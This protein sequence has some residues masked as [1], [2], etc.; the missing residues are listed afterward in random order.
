MHPDSRA[1]LDM[2]ATGRIVADAGILVGAT[3]QASA[4]AS[5]QVAAA[6]GEAR[7]IGHDRLAGLGTTVLGEAESSNT[8]ESPGVLM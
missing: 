8:T 7:A 5:N 4:F 6:P 1:I 3:A 2:L